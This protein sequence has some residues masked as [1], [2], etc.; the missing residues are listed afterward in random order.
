MGWGLTWEVDDSTQVKLKPSFGK[1]RVAVNGTVVGKISPWS[2]Q[3]TLEF[4]L[5]DESPARLTLSGNFAPEYKLHV[6]GKLIIPNNSTYRMLC[7]SCKTECKVNDAFCTVCGNAL[8][9]SE[10]IDRELQ[11]KKART[12]IQVLSGMFLVFG[13]IMFFM[14][15]GVYDNALLQIAEM[16][17]EDKVPQ[18]ING[19]SYLVGELRT[20]LTVEK[21][22]IL[23]LN[24]FLSLIM[25]G[26]S[27]WAKTA[28]L[29]AILIATAIYGALQVLNGIIDPSTI[30]QGW[31]VKFIVITYLVR[32]IR[33]TLELRPAHVRT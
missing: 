10:V 9:K 12:T 17:A 13:I 20:Q 26:L 3:R 21:Y 6:R 19:K 25:L 24:V 2:S 1:V 15:K 16:A 14:Q 5:P 32:G 7:A 22:S 29:G 4:Q 23:G 33:S 31:I 30:A 11:I 27:F 18:L 8:P 28:P